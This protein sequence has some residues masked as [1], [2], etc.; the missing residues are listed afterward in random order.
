LPEG[1]RWLQVR[2]LNSVEVPPEIVFAIE[3]RVITADPASDTLVLGTLDGQIEVRDRREWRQRQLLYG[4]GGRICSIAVSGDGARL[5]SAG[6]DG[7]ARLW[8]LKNTENS[9]RLLR[10]D[11]VDTAFFAADG[12]C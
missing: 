10:I 1:N 2:D 8:R 11:G 12:A 4:H 7:S 9:R 6:F 3:A 5:A